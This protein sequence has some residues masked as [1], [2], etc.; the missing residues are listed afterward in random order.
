[1]MSA[2]LKG[3]PTKMSPKL[4]CHKN[5]NVL[6]IKIKIKIQRLA[7]ITLVLFLS[8]VTTFITFTVADFA[9]NYSQIDFSLTRVLIDQLGGGGVLFVRKKVCILKK[10]D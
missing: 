1:M 3:H 7:L 2:K 8:N 10:M 6:E 5:K 4:K 9:N